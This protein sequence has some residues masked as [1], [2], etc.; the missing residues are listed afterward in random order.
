MREG[1]LRQD[2][3]SYGEYHDV[4]M[5]GILRG[6]MA[7]HAGAQIN[8][9][10]I[11]S[12]A[13]TIQAVNREVSDIMGIIVTKFGGSSLA[14]AGQFR[15]VR[16]ILLANPGG[17]LSYRPRPASVQKATSRSPTCFTRV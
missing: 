14:D 11:K 2:Y 3:Y 7:A 6:R 8:I 15:K 9:I 4:I 17:G 13:V 10:Y 1:V 16:D 5:M 12:K